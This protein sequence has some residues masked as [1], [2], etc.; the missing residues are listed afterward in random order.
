MLRGGGRAEAGVAGIETGRFEMMSPEGFL[1]DQGF[2]DSLAFVGRVAARPA[3]PRKMTWLMARMATAVQYL[4]Y[5][6]AA[7]HKPLR[8][9]AG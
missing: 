1:A 8:A 2:A 9:S 6:L 4:G 5:L 3:P 7:G